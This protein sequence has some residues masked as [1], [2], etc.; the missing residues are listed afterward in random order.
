M[1]EK[2]IFYRRHRLLSV[3]SMA[4]VPADNRS[5]IPLSTVS[6]HNWSPSNEE[7]QIGKRMTRTAKA[8]AK[9]AAEQK[10]PYMETSND[11]F[12]ATCDE[13]GPQTTCDEDYEP[14]CESPSESKEEKTDS[15]A[16]LSFS[17]L[18][19]QGLSD[20][21]PACPNEAK[22]AWYSPSYQRRQP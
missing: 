16:P 2:V 1:L 12:P 18:L 4:I 20:P 15:P 3:S 21:D 19:A 10:R 22:Q 9:A 13:G 7:E 5:V 8:A 17:Q 6:S 14:L 11:H